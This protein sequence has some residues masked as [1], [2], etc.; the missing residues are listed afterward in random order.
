MGVYRSGAAQALAGQPVRRI[1]AGDDHRISG[2][3][4]K[5]VWPGC[6]RNLTDKNGV[7]GASF[8]ATA[9]MSRSG[10]TPSAEYV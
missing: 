10:I 4:G 9:R 1:G 5:R 8:S 7:C 2:G 6:P 3:L